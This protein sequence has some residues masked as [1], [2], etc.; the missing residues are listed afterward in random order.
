MFKSTSDKD[1]EIVKPTK[2]TRKKEKKS[3]F[4]EKELKENKPKVK[5][6]LCLDGGGIRGI[7][8]AEM[9]K[10]IE[11]RTNRKIHDIFDLVCGTSTGGLLTFGLSSGI[12]E[13]SDCF[14]LYSSFGKSM[15]QIGVSEKISNIQNLKKQGWYDIKKMETT[16]NIAFGDKVDEPIKN[17]LKEDPKFFMVAATKNE[18]QNYCS[19]IFR[20]Y[21]SPFKNNTSPHLGSNDIEQDYNCTIKEILRATS[22]APFYFEPVKINNIEYVDGGLTDL[23]PSKIAL[24]EAIELWPNDQI[25]LVSL[26]CGKQSIQSEVHSNKKVKGALKHFT[27]TF[28]NM[29]QTLTDVEK[30]H[31]DLCDT[32]TGMKKNSNIEY[33][34]LNPPDLGSIQLDEH[35][36]EVLDFMEGETELYCENENETF[37]HLC[38]LLGCLELK[39]KITLF[40]Q[41]KF[42]PS[43]FLKIRFA[44]DLMPMDFNGSS[45]PYVK[46]KFNKKVYTTRV[47]K[48][49]LNPKWYQKFNLKISSNDLLEYNHLNELYIQFD[50]FDEDLLKS[51]DRLGS[52]EFN[53]LDKKFESNQSYKLNFKLQDTLKGELFIEFK[54]NLWKIEGENDDDENLKF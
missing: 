19:Y 49:S 15:F 24:R 53:V 51:D 33:F 9:L 48:K 8:M 14:E 23:N 32:I 26:G 25:I 35:R 11:K 18:T 29:L 2:P 41:P 10:E 50:L 17:F 28:M 3:E 4:R 1:E 38:N 31:L 37:Q 54:P 42:L 16:M 34:R 44:L 39:K 36:D 46:I 6:M 30:I 40:G 22:A 52:C 5:K 21:I 45:D 20:S 13:S 43:I 47:I 27:N 7:I 12:L